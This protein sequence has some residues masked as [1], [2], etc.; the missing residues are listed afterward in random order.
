MTQRAGGWRGQ[1]QM[2]PSLAPVSGQGAVAGAV[3]LGDTLFPTKHVRGDKK[4]TAR[5]RYRTAQLLKHD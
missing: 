3:P 1:G 4:F 5:A 2:P